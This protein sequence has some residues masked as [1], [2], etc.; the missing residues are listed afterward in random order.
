MT[1]GLV[2]L[3]PSLMFRANSH[4]NAQEQLWKS[5]APGLGG[6]GERWVSAVGT[7]LTPL[8]CLLAR[9]GPSWDGKGDRAVSPD[10]SV[11]FG[12]GRGGKVWKVL[13]AAGGLT[14]GTKTHRGL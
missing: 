9:A 14:A 12:A 7:A 4:V 11:C 6:V 13:R 1:P 5:P 3:F 8:P 10:I 2:L